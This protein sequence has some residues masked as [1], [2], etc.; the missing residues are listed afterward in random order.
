MKAEEMNRSGLSR[1]K[2]AGMSRKEVR[3]RRS[4]LESNQC[5]GR[6]A[7]F[8]KNFLAAEKEQFENTKRRRRKGVKKDQHFDVCHEEHVC[9]SVAAEEV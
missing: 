9:G 4:K 3:A 2:T 8:V 1:R 6:L 5:F 7:S